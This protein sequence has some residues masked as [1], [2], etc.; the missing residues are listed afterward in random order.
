MKALLVY[1]RGYVKD[2][3]LGPV[4]KLIEACFELLVPLVIAGIVDTTIPNKDQ[5]HLFM[6]IFLLFGLAFV[7]VVVAV[8]AQYFSSR[9]AV[10][11]AQGLT[12]NLYAKIMRLSKEKHD[13][14]G[15]S[16]LVT[17]LTGDTFQIQT[18]INQFLRLFLRAPI[19]VTGAIIMAFRISPRLT[20]WFLGMV[21][22]L[23]LIIVV[24]SRIVNPLYAKIRVINESI[25]T[26]T[27]Q[28]L[29][30]MRVI[31]AFGQSE[32]ELDNFTT[33]NKDLK[34]WQLKTGV[35][36]SLISPLTFL[37][38]N[39]T[40]IAILWKG[41]LQ[42]QGGLL[43]QG[44]LI[45]LV[46][47]LLQIL[48]ELLK[49]AMMLTNL[50]QSFI[51]A[52]RVET[53]FNLEDE[54]IKA[55]LTIKKADQEA[56]VLAIDQMSFTYPTASQPSLQGINLRLTEGESLGIIGGTGSGKSTL[57]NLIMN[58]YQPQLGSLTIF[59]N[60]A[61]PKNLKE[62]RSWVAYVPQKAE[63]FR[64]TIRS[65][66]TLGL[67]HEPSDQE[68]WHA[69]DMAQA[70]D[71]VRDK[72]LGLDEPVESFGRNFSGGQRQRLTIA[73][74]LMRPAPFLILDDS[75]SALDYL[76]ESRLL[77]AI[78]ENLTSTS[79]IIISQRTNS[80]KAVDQILVLDKGHQLGL[81]NHEELLATNKLYQDIHYSQHQKEAADE[82]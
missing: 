56:L 5:N 11:Y 18:G 14:I 75:T 9:A 62:W 48:T 51:S 54:D 1:F 71:F 73:R 27:R 24:A 61:S 38:V 3:I 47:Y 69:L 40:L 22:V 46:N 44:M 10:G 67:K 36:A 55:P 82:S 53:I 29:E 15:T 74:A 81:G 17:R 49:L 57:V 50:N 21:L 32:R 7:G 31:R 70:A 65:N 76:T 28:Q 8:S 52:K 20:L 2:S 58:L 33:V 78:R 16:S 66:L 13:E 41:N 26:S 42:I 37:V 77:A 80:L 45:A 4:F 19:I 39:M 79:L 68:L 34:T 25:V 12:N 6:M 23:T 35:I 60:Q 63:L 59:N 43:T 72:E 64:G 30:G